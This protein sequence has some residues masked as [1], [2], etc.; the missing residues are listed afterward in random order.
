MLRKTAI[1]DTEQLKMEL[2]K[3]LDEHV[4]QGFIDAQVLSMIQR[5]RDVIKSH[6]A[7]TGW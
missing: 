3:A 6:G 5:M 2:Q 7:M 1:Y 4:T